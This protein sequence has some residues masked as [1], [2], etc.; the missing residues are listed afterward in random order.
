MGQTKITSDP[1][2]H[3]EPPLNIGLAFLYLYV[4]LFFDPFPALRNG[5][6]QQQPEAVMHEGKA[7]TVST[8]PP[9]WRR[10]RCRSPIC[11]MQG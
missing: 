9:S 1:V 6:H 11:S 3:L 10:K 4:G 7:S 8:K 2:D 5:K